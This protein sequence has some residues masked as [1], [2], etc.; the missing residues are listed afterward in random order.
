MISRK[1]RLSFKLAAPSDL[2]CDGELGCAVSGLGGIF[3]ALAIIPSLGFPVAAVL[4]G[5][6]LLGH[7]ILHN[8]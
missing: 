8:Q 4:T 7:G 1:L 6:V 5:L 2:K 3:T